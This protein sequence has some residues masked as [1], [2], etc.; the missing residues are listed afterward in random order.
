MFLTQPGL[1]STLHKGRQ[2]LPSFPAGPRKAAGAQGKRSH[3][4]LQPPPLEL[5]QLAFQFSPWLPACSPFFLQPLG[6]VEI[7]MK[8]KLTQDQ[9]SCGRQSGAAA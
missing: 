6:T 4:G 5:Q 2:T 8:Q 1:P 9:R 7:N 3:W